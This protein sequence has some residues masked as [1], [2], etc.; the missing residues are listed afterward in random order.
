[1]K[2]REQ[3]CVKNLY[4]TGYSVAYTIK[5]E[6]KRVV[7]EWD[8]VTIKGRAKEGCKK[9]ESECET[10]KKSKGYNNIYVYL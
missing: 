3:K 2:I 5:A 4:G 1:M 10:A 8:G 6:Y 9:W 7:T